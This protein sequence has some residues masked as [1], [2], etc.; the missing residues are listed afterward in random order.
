MRGAPTPRRGARAPQTMLGEPGRRAGRNGETWPRRTRSGPLSGYPDRHDPRSLPRR[1]PSAG[2]SPPWPRPSA[3]TARS[4]WSRPPRSRPTWSTTATTASSSAGPRASRPR[5][6]P[7]RTARSCASSRDAVGDRAKVVAG[8]GTNVT[9]HSVEL[10]RQADKLGADGLLLVTPYY[11]KPGQAGLLHHF[12][13]VARATDVPVMLYDVPGP[14]R[15]HHRPGDLRR[16]P[17]ARHRRRRQGRRRRLRARHPPDRPRLRR[18]LR[19]RPRQPRLARPR[20]LRLRLGRRATPAADALAAMV[21]RLVR[22][23]T[24]P[25]RWRSTDRLL[26]AI[27]AIMSVPNYGATTAKAALAAARCDRQPR[28][29]LPAGAPGP[30]TRSPRCAPASRRPA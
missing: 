19:R 16:P 21:R 11:S 14:H 17:G 13:E 1:H 25:V 8:V 18:L 12:T 2:C 9:A 6:R 22:T 7:P 23:A 3:T 28:R 20:R 29:A 10:A 4:T 15:H 30:T 24:T 5:P 26:P 27:D